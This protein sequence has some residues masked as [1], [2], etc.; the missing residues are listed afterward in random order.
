[1]GIVARITLAVNSFTIHRA[2][3]FSPS[4]SF[5]SLPLPS[6]FLFPLAE[7]DDLAGASPFPLAEVGRASFTYHPSLDASAFHFREPGVYRRLRAKIYEQPHRGRAGEPRAATARDF[8]GG[9]KYVRPVLHAGRGFTT[10]RGRGT[11]RAVN[12]F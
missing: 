5:F 11:S 2:C 12:T 1:M 8:A 6:P 10:L 7:I 4:L 9:E 3:T